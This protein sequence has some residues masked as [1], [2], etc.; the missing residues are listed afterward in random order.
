MLKLAIRGSLLGW[1]LIAANAAVAQNAAPSQNNAKARQ[2]MSRMVANYKNLRSYSGSTKFTAQIAG[3]PAPPAINAQILWQ[4][5]Q[6]A[7]RIKVGADTESAV[8]DGAH[9]FVASSRHK[10]QIIKQPKSPEL[11]VMRIL[12]RAGLTGPGLSLLFNQPDTILAIAKPSSL[13]LAPST[14][15]AGVPVE[16][17]VSKIQQGQDQLTLTYGI[18]KRDGLLRRLVVKQTINGQTGITVETH[19]NIQVN[20]KIPRSTFVFTPPPGAKVVKAFKT[21]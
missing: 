11:G 18:G 3:Q 14:I 10:T 9:L 19:S 5:P 8:Y 16:V 12:S 15:V 4:K 7:L 6:A 13:S 20:A 21:S 17:V 2:I 1:M